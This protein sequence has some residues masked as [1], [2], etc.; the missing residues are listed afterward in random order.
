[1][2]AELIKRKEVVGVWTEKDRVVVGTRNQADYEAAILK[3]IVPMKIEQKR[4]EIRIIGEITAP[5]PSGKPKA[6]EPKA[7]D[8]TNKIR[9]APPGCSTGHVDITAGTLGGVFTLNGETVILSNN[10]VFANSNAGAKGDWILQPGPYDI[11]GP[12]PPIPDC[13][14]ANAVAKIA[15]IPAWILRRD[16]RLKAY[17]PTTKKDLEEYLIAYLEDFEPIDFSGGY[18]YI[19]AAIAM[20]LDPS[21]VTN[22]ILELGYATGFGRAEIGMPVVKSGRTTGITRGTIDAVDGLIKISYGSGRI[23]IF[24]NQIIT[25]KILEGGDSGSLVGEDKDPLKII[26]LGFAGSDDLSVVN[27]IG[28]VLERWPMEIA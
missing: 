15:N 7:V 24:A 9:P 16:S 14:I 5:P 6:I 22:E 27:P 11:N 1:M 20:P 8:R 13:P 26:G 23:A 10:H 17:R 28:Y 25:T 18:N 19:D 4:T 12:I 3:S 2:R 21:H